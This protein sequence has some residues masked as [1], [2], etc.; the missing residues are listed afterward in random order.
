[1]KKKITAGLIAL[2]AA[3]MLIGCYGGPGNHIP[4]T[5]N[6]VWPPSCE[7]TDKPGE[8][9]D[10]DQPDGETKPDGTDT[11]DNEEDADQPG[12]DDTEKPGEEETDQPGE[13]ESESQL[14]AAEDSILADKTAWRTS[15]NLFEADSHA[16]ENIQ[17][18]SLYRFQNDLLTTYYLYDS[19]LKMSFY[20][21][22]IISIENGEVLYQTKIEGPEVPEI[23]II[24]DQII[25]KDLGTK[26]AYVFDAQLNL[27]AEYQFD[28]SSFVFDQTGE[29]VYVFTSD[30]GV[31]IIDL[32]TDTET[33]ILEEERSFYL[34]D[35]NDNYAS[36]TYVDVNT[37]M[38]TGGILNLETGELTAFP[39]E[40]SPEL[41][42]FG[43]DIWLSKLHAETETYVTGK[44][45]ALKTFSAQSGTEVSF[46]NGSSHI[47]QKAY[48]DAWQ[49][50]LTVYDSSGKYLSSTE[51]IGTANSLTYEMAW[52]EEYNGYFF[53]MMSD[54]DGMD[55][56]LFWD[57]SVESSGEDIVFGML[58]ELDVVPEGSGVPQE[59]FDRAEA[60]TE[61]YGMQILIADQC[62]TVFSDHT[63]EL[64][65]REE[66]LTMALNTIEATFASY[67]EGFFEQLK[68]NTYSQI[69][70]HVEGLL[71]KNTSTEEV[72]Y[73]SQAFV[74]TEEDKLVMVLDA[75][76]TFGDTINAT[77][78]QTIY[79]EFSHMI[80]KKLEFNSQYHADAVYSDE[81]WLALNP[82]GFEYN[83]SYY[84]TLDPA[85]EDY[86][87]DHYACSN[88]TEDRARV[89][90]HASIGSV[91]VFEGHQGLI[92]KL[93]Y[94][95]RGIRDGFDT[96][97][98]PEETPWEKT[99]NLVK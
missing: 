84:G 81:G 54:E 49:E 73:I 85:Y 93:D 89:M 11:P 47:L 67:P 64:L 26:K 25:L 1:M 12:K 51:L 77:L 62:D 99:L 57:L 19:D 39:L 94:Y 58:E 87:V 92:D 10:T 36:I 52:F 16:W 56:L 41:I 53:T 88:A 32:K 65:L 86:F 75:R 70:V 78:Q 42:A 8:E 61:K 95:C 91:D 63:G 33:F 2:L 74:F 97:G 9:E 14:P 72:M 21:M 34:C 83:N 27:A 40:K 30:A 45:D 22:N 4:G 71:K 20:Y 43:D 96:T 6:P 24:S 37:L 3:L 66:D 13:D 46:V 29:K 48:N 18:S 55:R 38:K 80:D 44:L 17:G 59:Y 79:H 90:E 15:G 68:H 82:E 60:I 5:P 69:E 7:D 76:G 50:M 23:Q 31:Q 35:V 28:S 98:W